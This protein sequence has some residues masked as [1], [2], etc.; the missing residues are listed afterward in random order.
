MNDKVT[1]I[2]PPTTPPIAD[3]YFPMALV[4]LGSF[5]RQNGFQTEVI[6]FDLH[7]RKFPPL[8]HWHSLKEHVLRELEKT[9]SEIFGISSIC[10]NYPFALLLAKEIR[11][12]WPHSKIILGGPQ[13]SAVPE[14]T[15]NYC[16]WIDVIVIGEGER[17]LLELVSSDWKETSLMK[18]DGIAFRE[19]EKIR[20]TRKRDL[21]ANLDE[22]PFPDFSLIPLRDYHMP[23]RYMPAI[24]E[25]G[26]GCPFTCSFCSTALMW[27]RQ[28]R[29]KSP[30]RILEEMRRV[31]AEY[32]SLQSCF[33][34]THDNFTTSP[35]YVREFC[36]FMKKNNRD[37]FHWSVSARP[38]TVNPSKMKDLFDAGCRAVFFGVDTGSQRMQKVIDKHLRLLDF[39]PL[40]Q[41]TC[42]MGIAATT[43]FIIGYPEETEED[44]NETL[45]WA[46][47]AK[48]LGSAN[49]Q[50]HRI[51][52]LASTQ[53]YEKNKLGLFYQRQNQSDI[54]SEWFRLPEMESMILER[55]G[56]FSSFYTIPTPHLKNLNVG[57][58]ATFFN[59]VIT[60]FSPF[61]KPYLDGIDINAS[62]IFCDWTL[63]C[64]RH[65]LS[66]AA[67]YRL[68]LN[69]FEEFWVERTGRNPA[70]ENIL[71]EGEG[72]FGYS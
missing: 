46:L 37:G 34:L 10:W 1:L 23:P 19:G 48:W 14:E 65:G 17:T 69:R 25:A 26:R 33:S 24:I 64:E 20:R 49:V 18:I 31:K 52:P 8:I 40:L 45:A 72:T 30:G 47:R 62:D 32:G 35:R 56:L 58:M 67:D 59:W 44:L 55:K 41:A 7:M 28:Y 13:P 22:L 27:E 16:P 36:D 71:L 3:I 68:I 63:W 53:I 21:I 54:C 66:D 43:S 2:N 70:E 9:G 61:L 11:N 4:S 5:L 38:D 57:H 15:L 60:Y 12:R 6:D 42:A 50:V 39:E 51:A 29:A